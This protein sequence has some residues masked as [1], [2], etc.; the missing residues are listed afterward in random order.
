MGTTQAGN[1]EAGKCVWRAVRRCGGGRH[2]A[3]AN[4]RPQ[5]EEY[6]KGKVCR[7]VNA[8]PC[9]PAVRAVRRAAAKNCSGVGMWEVAAQRP[10]EAGRKKDGKAKAKGRCP[11]GSGDSNAYG[12]ARAKGEGKNVVR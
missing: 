3:Q 11:M 8:Q 10:P 4:G 6:A 5:G 7:Q 9:T 1:S 12:K 2:G